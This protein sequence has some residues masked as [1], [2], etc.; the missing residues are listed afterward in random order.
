MASVEAGDLL[1]DYAEHGE[2]GAP[3]VLLIHGWPD[4]VSTW[5]AVAPVIAASGRR[6]IVPSLRG[7][8]GTRFLS[9]DAPRTGDSATLALD[10][11][12]LLDALGIGRVAVAGHD[13][14]SNTAE[15]MAVGWPDRIERLALLST[16][17]RLGGMSTPPF[18]HAQRQWY[19]WFMATARGAKAVRE[20][21]RGF[22][23]IHWENWSPEGWFDDAT[24]DRVALSWDNPD[25]VDVTLHS[26]RLRWDEAEPDA[27]SR[28]LDDK[29]K[30]TKTLSLPA[31][32]IQGEV[33]GVN[34][35][36]AAASVPDKFD[37]PFEFVT[38]PGIGHFPQR[39]RAPDVARLLTEFFAGERPA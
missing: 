14:G 21:R 38:L 2:A 33:D 9:A 4:D 8:G 17:P 15:A 18:W 25:W 34:P 6:V 24:F 31:L 16:P 36:A 13:W 19:H 1:I 37:G 29:V 12:A 11:I 23:R 32:Y 7:F 35:P 22:A 26:Y 5:D 27:R 10:M 30:A 20:D 28:W 3:P 39:E